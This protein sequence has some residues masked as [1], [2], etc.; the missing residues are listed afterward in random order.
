[1]VG[2]KQRLTSAKTASA[3]RAASTVRTSAALPYMSSTAFDSLWKDSIWR[4]TTALTS[5]SRPASPR[6]VA[7]ASSTASGAVRLSTNLGAPN[8]ASKAMACSMEA[9]K[10]SIR[11][12]PR[13]LCAMAPRSSCMV[14]ASGTESPRFM[15]T[16]ISSPSGVL[17]ATSLRM[18]SPVERCAKPR[19]AATILPHCVER[20]APGPPITQTASGLKRPCTSAHTSSTGRSELSDVTRPSFA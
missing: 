7:R 3:L 18:R 12:F 13:G 20:P 19:S 8:S 6:C 16:A 14:V 4:L 9:G 5:L 1:M 2:A 15:S 10:P 17:R 11:Y